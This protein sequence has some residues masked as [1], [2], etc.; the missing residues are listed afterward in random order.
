MDSLQYTFIV[1]PRA[2]K[3]NIKSAIEFLFER[4]VKDVNV[5]NRKG[6]TKRTRFGIGKKA[7]TK[8]AIVTLK[9]GE[10]PIDVF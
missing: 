6:K 7:D 2:N 1:N 3:K 5:V 10:E 4:K 9:D 8:R